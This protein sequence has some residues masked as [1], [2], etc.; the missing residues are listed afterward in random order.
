MANTY[1]FSCPEGDDPDIQVANPNPNKEPKQVTNVPP[2]DLEFQ[3]PGTVMANHKT[4]QGRGCAPVAI[5]RAEGSI[6]RCATG[7]SQVR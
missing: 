6:K 5:W 4:M 2:P 1:S 7:C 3:A